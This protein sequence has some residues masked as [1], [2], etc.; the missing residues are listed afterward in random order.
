MQPLSPALCPACT[1]LP[2][3]FSSKPQMLISLPSSVSHFD[4]LNPREDQRPPTVVW[5]LLGMVGVVSPCCL[6]ASPRTRAQ[7]AGREPSLTNRCRRDEGKPVKSFIFSFL[8]EGLPRLRD[9]LMV[10]LL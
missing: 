2:C 4:P 6:G 10:V 8:M 5:N 7:I 3:E 9:Y 1:C